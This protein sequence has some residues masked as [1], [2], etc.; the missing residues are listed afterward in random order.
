MY[1][2]KQCFLS[3]LVYHKGNVS[4]SASVQLWSTYIIIR[5]KWT[6]PKDF[7][8]S[9]TRIVSIKVYYYLDLDLMYLIIY[10]KQ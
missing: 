10:V 7:P 4:T 3:P 1:I 9:T 5:S 2:E 6:E 8:V